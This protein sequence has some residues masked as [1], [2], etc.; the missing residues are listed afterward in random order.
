MNC[1]YLKGESGVMLDMLLQ[2]FM[3]LL[4]WHVCLWLPWPN[5]LRAKPQTFILI[6]GM[7]LEQLLTLE[8]DGKSEAS[9]LLVEIKLKMV[10]C[11]K[12]IRCHTPPRHFG[13]Y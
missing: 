7:P 5:R 2:L 13:F 9:L 12:L 3:K 10:L 11:P 6:G 8:H 1:S 4:R